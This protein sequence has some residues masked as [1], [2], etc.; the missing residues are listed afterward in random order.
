MGQCFEKP[1]ITPATAGWLLAF[2]LA[3][4]AWGQHS[5]PRAAPAGSPVSVLRIARSTDGL[6]FADT[7]EVLT[8][9]A[10]AP[11]L[12][13]LPNDHLLAVFDYQDGSIEGGQ[14]VLAAS[15]STDDGRAWS[16]PRPIVLAGM[17]TNAAPAA[18]GDLV[19]T[20]SGLVR[21][22]FTTSDETGYNRGPGTKCFVACAVT[23]NGIDYELDRQVRLDC[24]RAADVHPSTVP[25]GSQLGLFVVG[26]SET[27]EGGAGG[28]VMTR[29]FISPDG[30]RFRPGPR[31]RWTG[32][33]GNVIET[34]RGVLRMFLSG[35][36]DVRSMS[37]T[38][39]FRWRREPGVRVRNAS[40][41]AVI[42]LRSGEYLMLYC[43]ELDARSADL[44]QMA[45]AST[46]ENDG[47]DAGA[48]SSADGSTESTVWSP[49]TLAHVNSE[50]GDD[51]ADD[52]NAWPDENDDGIYDTFAPVP[53]L[54]S[55]FDYLQWYSDNLV[56]AGEDNAFE[57]Y[58]DLMM[59]PR[60]APEWQ[61]RDMFHDDD[62]DGPPGPWDHADHPEWEESYE[63]S[64]ELMAQFREASMDPRP[65]AS[66]VMFMNDGVLEESPVGERTLIEISLPGL[67]GCRHLAKATLAQAWRTE[68]GL[69]DPEGMRESWQTVLGNVGHLRQGATLIEGLVGL[70]ER[71]LVERNAQW[72]LT[73]G[74]FDSA[75]EIEA[76]LRI[77]QEYDTPDSDPGHWLSGEHAMAM[78][79]AQWLVTPAEPGGEP[80][81]NPERARRLAEMVSLGDSEETA[82]AFQDLTPDEIREAVDVADTHYR[83]L[84]ESWR[85]GYPE[86][87]SPDL[88]AATEQRA[89]SNRLLKEF[90]PSLSRAYQLEARGEASR[91]A[92]QLAYGVHLFQAREGRWPGSLSE[93]PDE[94][95]WDVRTDPFTGEDFG[96]Q[97]TADGP[98]IYSLSE[99]AT[100]D[101]GIHSPRW[102]DGITN[103]AV[104]DDHVL[105][106]PQD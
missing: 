7:G 62:F 92:T 51:F 57:S 21:L 47:G 69:V 79:T 72:A 16:R 46:P 24:E 59:D 52:R 100:D 71:T 6:E 56:P 33:I 25:M 28:R 86:V 84:Q 30:R 74:V 27:R 9:N 50:L 93:L 10:S 61:F 65:Y 85:T 75:D 66:P 53:D 23:R 14:S 106:P 18:H 5:P 3:M 76:S 89:S 101:G 88:G 48:R 13:L 8:H 15:R 38:D 41:P 1:G 104:S 42:Q 81:V 12:I 54:Q 29:Q 77:L 105:W 31:V 32:F 63:A 73:H 67:A 4:P 87:R 37:S 82:A 95:A 80:R 97:L 68:N 91:R 36:G 55:R 19:L 49:F 70:A 94:D 102:A 11:D 2:L 45:R 90:L 43:T 98:T 83:E 17:G 35:R 44:P 22:Y 96:Y 20:P 99:N 40:D 64:Q 26:L 34:D 78:D 103:E 39:G 60:E 58:R